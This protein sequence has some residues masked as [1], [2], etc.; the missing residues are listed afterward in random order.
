MPE[1]DAENSTCSKIAVKFCEVALT[2]NEGHILASTDDSFV[3]DLKWLKYWMGNRRAT[4]W[5]P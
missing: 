1:F 2:S 4:F 3:L 5:V